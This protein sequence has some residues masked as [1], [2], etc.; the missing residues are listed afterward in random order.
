MTAESLRLAMQATQTHVTQLAREVEGYAAALAE[1]EERAES[2]TA[3]LARER[4]RIKT[5]RTAP[6]E[7]V[8]AA[9]ALLDKL[10]RMTTEDFARGAERDE[11]EGL[12][13]VLE[14][15]GHEQGR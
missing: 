3:A 13:A 4:T 6:D 10:D 15:I 5:L 7:L 2:A 12:R 8:A 11:R 1:V 14:V 9:A